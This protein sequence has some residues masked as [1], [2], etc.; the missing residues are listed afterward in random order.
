MVV[1]SMQVS[2]SKAG[3][4][5][6]PSFRLL[7]TVLERYCK[8]SYSP[9]FETFWIVFRVSGEL[10]DFGFEGCA[11]LR[12]ARKRR[13]ITV[14]YRIPLKQLDGKAASQL[15][16]YLATALKEALEVIVKKAKSEK[17][18]IYESRLYEDLSAAYSEYLK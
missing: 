9:S 18:T 16:D 7:H 3:R 8:N 15:R 13:Q 11:N 17:E 2:G 14:D 12:L 4:V 6:S 10:G 5:I 1:I